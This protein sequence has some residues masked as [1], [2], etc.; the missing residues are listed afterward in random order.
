MVCT[1]IADRDPLYKDVHTWTHFMH[2]DVLTISVQSL[3]PEYLWYCW[4][5]SVA[6][7]MAHLQPGI[8]GIIPIFVSDLSQPL[9]DRSRSDFDIY[10]RI[11]DPMDLYSIQSTPPVE[12]YQEAM[13]LA[14]VDQEDQEGGNGDEAQY[15]PMDI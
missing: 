3:S 4:K 1:K 11:T 12:G 6:I 8:N 9:G 10:N 15:E 5:H 13:N 7:Q 14:A 2:F